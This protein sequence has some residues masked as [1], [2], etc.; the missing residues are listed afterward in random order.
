MDLSFSFTD[1]LLP[2]HVGLT[3]AL[4]LLLI[5]RSIYQK[6]VNRNNNGRSSSI[7][8]MV[9]VTCDHD[10]ETFKDFFP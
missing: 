8:T 3:P 2:F 7:V 1:P 6:A 10:E 4:D 5:R 9:F